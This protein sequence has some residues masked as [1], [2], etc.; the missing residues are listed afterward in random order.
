[1]SSLSIQHLNKRL[2]RKR[3]DLLS[4]I[5]SMLVLL[6][7]CL[8]TFV[9]GYI[10]LL[11]GIFLFLPVT[12][13]LCGV[14][15]PFIA[16][17]DAFFLRHILTL[18]LLIRVLVVVYTYAWS[19]EAGGTG[20]Q[21]LG[22]S[23][24]YTWDTV[25]RIIAEKWRDHGFVLITDIPASSIGFPYIL[26]LF[27]FV[28]GHDTIVGMLLN[29]VFGVGSVALVYTLGRE[30]G[31]K[32]VGRLAGI[33]ASFLPEMIIWSSW[34]AKDGLI[35]LLLTAI[36]LYAARV[37]SGRAPVLL[38]TVKML[39]LTLLLTTLRA[40]VGY[41]MGLGAVIQL[42]LLKSNRKLGLIF[43][44][45]I[46]V[47]IGYV[48]ITRVGSFF[49]EDYFNV[50]LMLRLH[51]ENSIWQRYKDFSYS[52]NPLSLRILGEV[53]LESFL[54]RPYLLI[55]AFGITLITPFP[56]WLP[57][58]PGGLG[59]GWLLSVNLTPLRYLVVLFAGIGAYLSY[60]ESNMLGILIS[61][62]SM[63]LLISIAVT[64][65]GTQSR[66]LTQVL[67]LLAVLA[68]WS[69]G[70]LTRKEIVRVVGLCLTGITVIAF[71]YMVLK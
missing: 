13:I 15:A 22:L 71:I 17:D 48:V 14:A 62:L 68:A 51:M 47:L 64:F 35:A 6:F 7:I 18:S 54:A 34:L 24:D 53:S 70:R 52:E 43:L 49:S 57:S 67:P 33:V 4:V 23:D 10:E 16:R 46:F 61:N 27:Y 50:E 26:A 12:I 3:L 20:S 56:F 63:L 58:E 60:K 37:L 41:I 21:S 25:A 45:L 69:I 44:T 36:S 9:A 5:F 19:R 8:R 55:P 40:P 59:I 65:F 11:T 31:G 2:A 30:L 66:Y 32:D 28:F 1:M 39:L 38:G 29:V 42:W